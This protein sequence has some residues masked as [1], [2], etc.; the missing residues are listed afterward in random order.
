MEMRAL[1][2]IEMAEDITPPLFP[3]TSALH[4]SFLSTHCSSCFSLLPNPPI[5]HSPLLH[6]CSLKC[7]LSHSDPLTAAF[8]SIHPL[9][10]ASSDTSD[11]RASLRLLH[12]HLLLSH[13]SPSLSPPP[14][15]IF[16]LLTNRHKLMT[17][18][19]GSEVF[20]KLREAA[21]AIAALRRK[22]YADISPGTALEEAVLCLVLTNAVDVQD[23]IG[24]TIGIA[25]YAPTFSWINHSCSPNACYRFETPSDSFT[26][27]FRIA[28]SCTDFVSDE[29]TCRQVIV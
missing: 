22:I 18:Q 8:F 13:P 28:P 19:N 17:P 12:L 14:H 21:N 26:T 11:L 4:D 27:R 24:Q 7:S 29:G 10:D 6:Y 20:L 1:E 5:S 9:P 16:G 23:S 15:R 3:L 25:V 2:D